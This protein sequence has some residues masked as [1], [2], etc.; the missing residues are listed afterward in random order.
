V[1]A[2]LTAFVVL[3]IIFGTPSANAAFDN[4]NKLLEYCESTDPFYLGACVGHITAISDT[5][6]TQNGVNGYF[7]CP[8]ADATRQQLMDVVTHWLREHPEARHYAANGITARA[9]SEAFPC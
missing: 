9:L 8:P 2:R 3:A 7:A 5:L 1:R 6:A 4:G